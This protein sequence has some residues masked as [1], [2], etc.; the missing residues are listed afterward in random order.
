MVENTKH[1]KLNFANNKD[2]K[3]ELKDKIIIYSDKIIKINR[4][5]MSQDR[6]IVIT[7]KGL[8]NFKKKEMKRKIELNLITGIS[9]SKCT[10]EFVVHGDES[11]YDY[12]YVSSGRKLIIEILANTYAKLTNKNLKLC[13]LDDKSLKNFVTL[14]SEKKNDKAFSRMPKND[15]IF[16]DEF[17][18]GIKT[19][20]KNLGKRQSTI[21]K[22]VI[23]SREDEGDVHFDDFQIISVVGRGTFGK[24]CL[25]EYK[26][27]GELYAMKAIKKDILID[28]DQIKNTVLE[29]KILQSIKHPFLCKLEF[30]FQTEDRV[31]FIINFVRGG[32]LFQH[33]KNSFIFEENRVKFY[34]V[35][36][37]LALEHLHSKKIIYRDLKPENILMDEEGY[38]QLADFGMAKVLKE[39]EKA[40]SFCGT[41]EYLAPEIITEEGHDH[42]A[43]WWSY[44]ILM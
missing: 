6:Q 8:Y 25:V 19:D 1:D 14:K 44:G 23:I 12:D 26:N 21:I 11:E 17:L 37:G 40:E 22:D 39:N 27:T 2:I 42:M 34:A 9:I 24:V 28:S 16:L 3:K 36:I 35:Q 41:P 33:L 18:S 38:L 30:C 13:I 29:K 5:N 31:Y 7:N 15:H 32:E 20:S 43:D 10:D 4:Y